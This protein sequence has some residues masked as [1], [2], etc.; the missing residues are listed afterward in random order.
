MDASFSRLYA[1][2]AARRTRA[3]RGALDF[4]EM[5]AVVP[6]VANTAARARPMRA[7]R[8]TGSAES[9]EA[10]LAYW[11]VIQPPRRVHRRKAAAARSRSLPAA[12]VMV[13]TARRMS[14][15]EKHPRIPK[16][17]APF[18]SNGK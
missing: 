12:M 13:N 14:G 3:A 7:K 9:K 5:Q 2:G 17:T 11:R 1:A 8:R 16:G 10:R 15:S 18:K 4:F 6:H